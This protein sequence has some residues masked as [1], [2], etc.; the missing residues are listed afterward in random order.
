MKTKLLTILTLFNLHCYAQNIVL[1]EDFNSNP[2]TEFKVYNNRIYNQDDEEWEWTW[3]GYGA[4]GSYR[5]NKDYL[6]YGQADDW[7]ISKRIDLENYNN[8]LKFYEQRRNV[9]FFR[10]GLCEVLVNT[11]NDRDNYEDYE[12]I[13]SYS[14]EA[15]TNKVWEEKIIDLS[16]YDGQ[17]VY[18]AFR[19]QQR[20]GHQWLVDEITVYGGDIENPLEFKIISRLPDAIS[21]SWNKNRDNQQVILLA[22]TASELNNP[23]NGNSYDIGDVIG[24]ATV[25]YKGDLSEFTESGLIENTFYSY[26]L[27][28]YDDSNNY[29]YGI[30]LNTK[31]TMINTVYFEDFEDDNPNITNGNT[32][33]NTKFVVGNA[34]AYNGLR[35]LYV[36]AN[37]GNTASY[38]HDQLHK[39]GIDL[40]NIPIS[41]SYKSVSLNFYW[42]GI[43]EPGYDG[44]NVR[45]RRNGGTAYSLTDDLYFCGNGKWKNES[46]DITDYISKT[47]PAATY[48]LRFRWQAD[49]A[50]GYNPA[51][52]IDDLTIIGSVVANLNSFEGSF[53][54]E[55]KIGLTWTNR[56][57]EES[58]NV[59]IV[60]SANGHIGNLTD[61]VIYHTGQILPDG[62]T[63]IYTGP[64]SDLMYEHVD[65][66][67][68]NQYYKA[69]CVDATNNYSAPK[70][71]MVKMAVQLPYETSFENSISEWSMLGGNENHWYRGEA[72][73]FTGNKSMYISDNLG[74]TNSFDKTV[75]V[76]TDLRVNVDTR[77]FKNVYLTY[78]YIA[79]SQSGS[80]SRRV[81]VD[82][83]NNEESIHTANNA[84]DWVTSPV[85]SLD[86]DYMG[87]IISLD[88]QFRNWYT[89]VNSTGYAIDNVK[90]WGELYDLISFTG[91]YNPITKSNDLFIEHVNENVQVLIIANKNPITS[92]LTTGELYSEGDMLDDGSI[93]VY[94]GSVGDAVHENVQQLSTYYYK[95]YANK[96]DIYSNAKDLTIDITDNTIFWEDFDDV[97]N[98][99][100]QIDI[101]H[102]YPAG[103]QNIW[104]IGTKTFRDGKSLFVEDAMVSYSSAYPM[105][106][107]SLRTKIAYETPVDLSGCKNAQLTFDY[108]SY[109]NGDNGYVEIY[110]DGNIL[111][112]TAG[113]SRYAQGSN[114]WHTATVNLNETYCG[115]VNPKTLSILWYNNEG[116]SF[117]RKSFAIDNIKI[118][119]NV[120]Q[121]SIIAKVVITEPVDIQSTVADV[122]NAIE[123]MKFDIV[124]E[125]T[126]DDIDTKIQKLVLGTTSY[127]DIDNLASVLKGVVLTNG[128]NSIAGKIN[129]NSIVFEGSDIITISDGSADTYSLK[130]YL[131]EDSPIDIDNKK[132]GLQLSTDNIITDA[133][134]MFVGSQLIE[135]TGII[136]VNAT[137]LFI[138]EQPS[139][140]ANVGATLAKQPVIYATDIYG[141]KD[142]NYA[143][144]VLIDNT[145]GL[146]MSINGYTAPYSFNIVA[147]ECA[148]NDISINER[149]DTELQ[150]SNTVL[151]DVNSLTLQI[152]D[153]CVPTFTSNSPSFLGLIV[154]EKA[155]PINTDDNYAF[156]TDDEI[157]LTKSSEIKIRTINNWSG[158]TG[159]VYA[160][161]DWDQDEN[162]TST[163]SEIKYLGTHN[164][165]DN[166][167]TLTVPNDALY[168]YSRLRILITEN[169]DSPC[170]NIVNG[171]QAIDFIINVVDNEWLGNNTNFSSIDNWA[172]RIVPGADD[173]VLIPSNP[174]YGNHFPILN[175]DLIVTD[176]ILEPASSFVVNPGVKL[177][178]KENCHFD[179]ALELRAFGRVG[180]GIQ[181]PSFINE[182]PIG[183]SGNGEVKI[184]VDGKRYFYLGQPF[185]DRT[186]SIYNAANSAAV[187]VYE[188]KNNW[189]N[190]ANNITSIGEIQGLAVNHRDA[191]TINYTGQFKDNDSY[192]TPV[193]YRYTLVS[194]PYASSLDW[195]NNAGWE[196]SAV[197][198]TFH[199]RTTLTGNVRGYSSYN[200]DAAP[201]AKSVNGGTQYI[202]PFQA[203]FVERTG[204][205]NITVKKEARTHGVKPLLKSKHALNNNVL[206]FE[207]V[208]NDVNDESIVY[209]DGK[210]KLD[211]DKMDTRKYLVRTKNVP[212]IFSKLNEE[213]YASNALPFVNGELI[214]PLKIQT[215]K[216][217]GVGYINFK[218]IMDFNDS[219]GVYLCNGINEP[220]DIRD[221]QL[222]EID[223]KSDVVND[224][225]LKFMNLSTD[226]PKV[227]AND[228]E[229]INIYSSKNIITVDIDVENNKEQVI[230]IYE[231][232]GRIVSLLHTKKKYIEIPI[233]DPGIYVVKVKSG[234]VN[235]TSKVLIK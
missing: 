174:L 141:N 71:V 63:V 52:A 3:I 19:Y 181:V 142:V 36:S 87:K 222:V 112:N 176:L 152:R 225:Y 86:S 180:Y 166:T 203:F 121:N 137:Q 74:I 162:F 8:V 119:G 81:Y 7:L 55:N 226:L 22:G 60:H 136:N 35:S 37:N 153:Y 215:N 138:K 208:Y 47:D 178:V 68:G 179:G 85:I 123:F 157:K 33:A 66:F 45:I 185:K 109:G 51:F 78:D 62:G 132:L 219:Y 53:L 207:L 129:S 190:I 128:T 228:S 96:G 14:I 15:L 229:T 154:N 44:G 209:F 194:N 206:R 115:D 70:F 199:I 147:G 189:E 84:S 90:I 198:G 118:T 31:T 95:A 172:S 126:S 169:D 100:T 21:L 146:Q 205:G 104:K 165:T 29:S 234:Q 61:G 159:K 88:W 64:A 43:G 211:F 167:L 69:W 97:K 116:S 92:N 18:V 77:G 182:M 213:K 49:D 113:I 186:S 204:S 99:W 218:N 131:V 232:T 32:K 6:Y 108:Y 177:T 111:T 50:S 171:G 101:D 38:N 80:L 191:A 143:G 127:N 168:N 42:K 160:F 57:G 30:E 46:I 216:A 149:G 200:K 212:Q 2:S 72:I 120:D 9:S 210:A 158:K 98:V 83:G 164:S 170:Q 40:Q 163:A 73:A 155:Y 34:V 192:S 11:G 75:A 139:G 235:K 122:Y 106:W 56:T 187:R 1:K 117:Y 196:R 217:T 214:V 54:A 175:S 24:N 4:E 82:D 230:S 233:E 13:D 145:A 227:N 130:V 89:S 173:K 67:N 188:W 28:S 91:S 107:R 135:S 124:D 202:V 110:L 224:Y 150:F 140:F 223:L 193:S 220:I 79:D 27:C 48:K 184:S 231:L 93:V 105:Y 161:F 221:Q 125:G 134:S 59:T 156:L 10:T 114:S 20:S 151:A 41:N 17:S 76:E 133:G 183:G 65:T 16:A 5:I 39:I 58:N 201:G 94:K 195:E 23:V 144:F 102:E 103:Q 12:L 148:F 25:I 26:R 197:S